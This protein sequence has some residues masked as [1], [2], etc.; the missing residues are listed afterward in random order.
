MAKGRSKI[1]VVR[2]MTRNQKRKKAYADKA[3]SGRNQK[4][5]GK[6][7]AAKSRRR[8]RI[9]GTAVH[10]RPC[11]NHACKPCRVVA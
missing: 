7:A 2:G 4:G 3:A 1:G 8:V 5:T 10:V 9:V 6:H 11:G